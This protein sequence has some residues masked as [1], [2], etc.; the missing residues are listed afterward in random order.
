M[1]LA[2]S[3]AGCTAAL[4]LLMMIF[5]IAVIICFIPYFRPTLSQRVTNIARQSY[6]HTLYYLYT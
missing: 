6:A 5:G 2:C 3:D 1:L 4:V